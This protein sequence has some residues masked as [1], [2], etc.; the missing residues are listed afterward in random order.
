MKKEDFLYERVYNETKQKIISGEL[1][2]GSLLPSEK[3]LSQD[4]NVNRT[5]IR[6]ALLLLVADGLVVK[7]PGI[8]T[9]VFNNEEFSKTQKEN[10]IKKFETTEGGTIGLFVP[11]AENKKD[12]IS[13]PFYSEILFF[14]EREL[15]RFGYSVFYSSLDESKDFEN[16]L[17]Q[18]KLDGIIFVSN[19]SQNF[20]DITKKRNIPSLIVN[21]Y[22]PQLFS[23]LADNVSGM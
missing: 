4:Y 7:K 17:N 22:N 19:I 20:I 23:I 1:K 13:Q 3:E 18:Q 21:N 15:N 9:Q 5:T 10:L 11:P 2:K 14:V 12:R 16:L 6:K 8:G